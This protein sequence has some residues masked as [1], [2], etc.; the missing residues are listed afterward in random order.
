V[1]PVADV[2]AEVAVEDVDDAAPVVAVEVEVEDVDR[3]VCLRGDDDGC[4]DGGGDPAR[5]VRGAAEE[6]GWC[7]RYVGGEG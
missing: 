5:G 7:G 4:G 6:V 3:G 1:L 2:V